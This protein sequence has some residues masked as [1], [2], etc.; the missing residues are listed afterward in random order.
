MKTLTRC[1]ICI[2]AK[3]EE[4]RCHNCIT[5]R[6]DTDVLPYCS[7]DYA[8]RHEEIQANAEKTAV[9]PKPE[10]S[11][12][13]KQDLAILEDMHDRYGVNT[14]PAA[15]HLATRSCKFMKDEYGMCRT[16]CRELKRKHNLSS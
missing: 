16:D 8:A 11:H 6:G 7:P 13:T 3:W 12:A 4:Y 15:K 14:L 5:V 1:N 2:H 9:Y 10:V